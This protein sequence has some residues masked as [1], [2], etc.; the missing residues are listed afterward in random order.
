MSFPHKKIAPEAILTGAI[1]SVSLKKVEIDKR[2]KNVYVD[3]KV[4]YPELPSP[5]DLSFEAQ[6]KSGKMFEVKNP[7]FLTGSGRVSDSEFEKV[8]KVID[9][10]NKVNEE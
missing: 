8:N 1:Q 6:L 10:S 2:I 3:N 9:K 7:E 4:A 5:E